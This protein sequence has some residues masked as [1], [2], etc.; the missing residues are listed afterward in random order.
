MSDQ[1]ENNASAPAEDAQALIYTLSHDLNAPLRGISG[2]LGLL[3]KS[4]S[5]KL[6]E[7]ELRW[8]DLV[9]ADAEK[10]QGQLN[11]LLSYSRLF[12]QVDKKDNVDLSKMLEGE[13]AKSKAAH[14]DVDFSLEVDVENTVHADVNHFATLFSDLLDNAVSYHSESSAARV[15]INLRQDAQHLVFSIEDNGLGV[16][17]EYFDFIRGVF[18]R[19]SRDLDEA[20]H[21]GMGLANCER[22]MQ[23]YQGEMNFAASPLGGLKVSCRI[24]LVN[25]Q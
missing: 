22:I 5:E 10:A 25:L 18:K 6:D 12:T 15:K 2:L 23:C 1:H 7:K 11:S 4:A 14:P 24:P 17:E 19:L 9:V 8:L 16:D 21:F 20:G 3:K 13:L